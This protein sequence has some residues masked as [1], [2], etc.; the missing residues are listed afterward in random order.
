MT[1]KVI[2]MKPEAPELPEDLRQALET[3]HST[4]LE[5]SETMMKALMELAVAFECPEVI[6]GHSASYNHFAR[7]MSVATE[8]DL[9]R[10]LS[11]ELPTRWAAKQGQAD[12]QQS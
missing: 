4:I 2:E 8:F 5:S 12:A 6:N 10:L 1:D 3:C 11:Y 7:Q 9:Y